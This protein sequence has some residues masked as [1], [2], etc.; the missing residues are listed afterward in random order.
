MQE[1][2]EYEGSPLKQF[3]TEANL[4]HVD[5]DSIEDTHKDSWCCEWFWSDVL[6]LCCLGFVFVDRQNA[7]ADLGRNNAY[8]QG[9]NEWM[10]FTS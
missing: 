2:P 7:Y 4:S 9:K 1:W 5:D 6:F 8:F 3:L 10:N